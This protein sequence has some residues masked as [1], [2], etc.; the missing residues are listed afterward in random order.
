MKLNAGL[1]LDHREAV[2]VALTDA[3]HETTRVRSGS[4]KHPGRAS[5]PSEGKFKGREAPADDSRQNELTG[6]LVRYYDEIIST[7]RGAVSIFIFGPG[8]AK[9]E[10]KRRFDLHKIDGRSMTAETAGQMTEAQI[11]AMVRRHF[12]SDAPRRGV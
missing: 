10:L 3:G 12:K 9:E 11:V 2:V 4:E 1:W 7:L 6:E 8:E 5:S